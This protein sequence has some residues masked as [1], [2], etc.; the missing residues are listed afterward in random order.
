ME[1]HQKTEEQYE[2]EIFSLYQKL[3]NEPAD[4]RRQVFVLQFLD[5]LS[6]WSINCFFRNSTYEYW[7]E[8]TEAVFR[9]AKYRENPLIFENAN[10][11]FRYLK[12]SLSRAKAEYHRKHKKEENEHIYLPPG[13]RKKLKEIE[14]FIRLK[15]CE[16]ERQ[17]SDYEKESEAAIWFN[18]PKKKIR[19]YLELNAKVNVISIND[20]SFKNIPDTRQIIEDNEPEK[21]EKLKMALE[22]VFA[23]KQEKTRPFHKAL[24]TAQCLNGGIDIKFLSVYFEY[25]NEYIDT[26]IWETYEKHGTIPI[27]KE[28]FLKFYP[29]S[30]NPSQDVS[31]RL[32]VFRDKLKE[33][34]SSFDV[35]LNHN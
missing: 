17:L 2:N 28:I 14:D 21:I 29:E 31:N 11:F 13:M 30:K 26:E 16:L 27:D 35:L 10:Y 23:D 1:I 4:D 33:A 9:I 25:L 24:F 15:E 32:K 3:I 18:L 6:K 5:L 12:V 19:Y 8:I 20:A 22:S 34:E 7:E